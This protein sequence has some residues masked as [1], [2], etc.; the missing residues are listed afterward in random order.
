MEG[1]RTL[2]EGEG[3]EV[4]KERDGSQPTHDLSRA[5]LPLLLLAERRMLMFPAEGLMKAAFL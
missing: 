4:G 3:E 5:G 2:D 1:R